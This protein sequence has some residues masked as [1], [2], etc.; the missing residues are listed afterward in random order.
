M[1]QT[2]QDG[3]PAMAFAGA[4]VGAGGAGRGVEAEPVQ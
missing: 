3:T 4:G 2:A 1:I